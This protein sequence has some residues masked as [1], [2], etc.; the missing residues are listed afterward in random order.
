MEDRFTKAP[1]WQCKKSYLFGLVIFILL[2]LLGIG[3][4]IRIL[5]IEEQEDDYNAIL[6]VFIISLLVFNSMIYRWISTNCD[7][8]RIQNEEEIN[9]YEENEQYMN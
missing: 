2:T 4:I 5:S 9:L 7:K 3:G 1:L 6:I 8:R